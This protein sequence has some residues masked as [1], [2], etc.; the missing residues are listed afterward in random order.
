MHEKAFEAQ[1]AAVTRRADAPQDAKAGTPTLLALA[2]GSFC[3]GT[4]EFASM[5]VLQ[6]FARDLSLTIPQATNAVTAYAIGVVVGAP[7][8]T[9]SMARL[10]RRT[11]LLVLMG[12]FVVGNLISANATGLSSLMVARFLAGLPQGGYFGAGAVIAAYV[13]GADK[14]GK[15][16]AIVMTGLTV[17]TI[18]GSPIATLLG[19][20]LGWREAY[21][22][23]SCLGLLS[24]MVLWLLAPRTEALH[25][26]PVMQELSA[27]RRPSVWGL[28][29]VAAIGVGSIF[30]VYTFIGP[31]IT[32][33]IRADPSLIPVG[34]ALFGL[35]M[36]AGN[37]LGG[38]LADTHS[39]LGLAAGF[40]SALVV[41]ATIA[42]AG[43]YVW[44]LM[45]CL[46]GV[47][48]T[49]M[50]AIPTIQVRLTKLAPE[51]PTLM[52]AMN[53]ASLNIANAIGAWTGGIAIGLGYGGLSVGWAGFGCTLLGLVI[54]AIT[55]RL[56]TGQRVPSTSA[57]TAR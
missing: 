4:S 14:A 39:V 42:I 26:G 57:S 51:A 3:I 54:F 38:R 53:L 13:V 17:A 10:N 45:P 33:V 40:G 28:M 52:G 25:G 23:I 31:I 48:L 15:A 2:F 32:D 55:L 37:I 35:G 36:T 49:M 19:Q 1:C 30:A 9:L 50:T 21:Q 16:F 43:A 12:L 34:L 6:L 56:S 47:G 5:G 22:A 8:V 46:F 29:L 11:V 24:L 7:L 41:L 20:R 18:F 44:V 27:L